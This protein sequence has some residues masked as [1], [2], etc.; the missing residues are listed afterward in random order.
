M[1]QL[2][3]CVCQGC[4]AGQR[5][6]FAALGARV[7]G[8]GA[9]LLGHM[10]GFHHGTADDRREVGRLREGREP[11]DVRDEGL[12]DDQVL[13][14]VEGFF[15]Q[16]AGRAGRIW[17]QDLC[18]PPWRRGALRPGCHR[19][20]EDTGCDLCADAAQICHAGRAGADARRGEARR[21][22]APRPDGY[23]LFRHGAPEDRGSLR[24]HVGVR[25]SG[26]CDG[27]R[28]SGRRYYR[29]D[30]RGGDR[31]QGADH[32][33]QGGR[34]GDPD[35]YGAQN[36]CGRRT[37]FARRVCA[38]HVPRC[39]ETRGQVRCQPGEMG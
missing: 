33:G 3:R 21:R 31:R 17:R 6:P 18:T 23:D 25:L 12:A 1:R 7:A 36:L 11:A 30:V 35:A 34:E 29:K 32:P 28:R 20:A 37:G 5:P 38:G 15:G 2:H 4:L 22:R 10:A 13:R 27:L 24:L 9:L 16:D 8:R 26:G 19:Y 39:G 14:F